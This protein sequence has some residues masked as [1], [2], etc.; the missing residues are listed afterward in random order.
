LLAAGLTDRPA[1]TILHTALT[2][3]SCMHGTTELSLALYWD[4]SQSST[5]PGRSQLGHFVDDVD[6]SVN[7]VVC[8]VARDKYFISG[9]VSPSFS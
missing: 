2:R 7:V 1:S 8:V 9:S 3:V 5:F 6:Y 4:C